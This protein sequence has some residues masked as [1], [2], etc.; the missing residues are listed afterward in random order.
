[1]NNTKFNFSRFQ[2]GLFRTIAQL[3]V[4]ANVLLSILL[5]IFS[6]YKGINLFQ[7]SEQLGISLASFYFTSICF[8]FTLFLYVLTRVLSKFKVKILPYSQDNINLLRSASLFYFFALLP[9]T[10]VQMSINIALFEYSA[11]FLQLSLQFILVAP[12]L[13]LLSLLEKTNMKNVLMTLFFSLYTT[14][15][16]LLFF[17]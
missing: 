13:S 8:L 1:M 9:V 5:S 16:F 15:L 7:D 6:T 17:R 10:L 11:A 3:I 4:N 12:Y 2:T 14:L